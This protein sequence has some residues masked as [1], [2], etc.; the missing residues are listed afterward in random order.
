MIKGNG[1]LINCKVSI[2]NAKLRNHLQIRMNLILAEKRRRLEK[3]FA[4]MKVV[5][6]CSPFLALPQ[7]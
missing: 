2:A 3:L 7:R 4:I 6:F 5:R 1:A